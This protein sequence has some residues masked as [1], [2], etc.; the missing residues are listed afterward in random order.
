MGRG[1][2][3]LTV[4]FPEKHLAGGSK[5]LVR[6]PDCYVKFPIS[7]PTATNL[8]PW[9][10]RLRLPG[11]T[12]RRDGGRARARRTRTPA[13]LRVGAG[14]GGDARGVLHHGTLALQGVLVHGALLLLLQTALLIAALIWAAVLPD[15]RAAH[16]A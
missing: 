2:L 12:G 6:N 3:L 10:Q 4:T 16:H 8:Q 14:R 11:L 5:G 15:A 13:A 7:A 1:H 9:H